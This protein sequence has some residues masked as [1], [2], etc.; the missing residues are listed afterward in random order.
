[1]RLFLLSC[2]LLL[3]IDIPFL[4]MYQCFLVSKEG[5]RQYEC[6]FPTELFKKGYALH[7]SIIKTLDEAQLDP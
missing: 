2:S 4:N 7:H 6:A 3:D 1:M 5:T